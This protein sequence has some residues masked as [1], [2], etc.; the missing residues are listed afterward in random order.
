MGLSGQTKVR[1]RYSLQA[2]APQLARWLRE[3]CAQR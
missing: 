2:A 1:A 3:V